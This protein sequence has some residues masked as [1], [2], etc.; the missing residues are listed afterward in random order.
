VDAVAS[1]EGGAFLTLT[2][3]PES[4]EKVVAMESRPERHHSLAAYSIR[5]LGIFAAVVIYA[6]DI[7]YRSANAGFGPDWQCTPQ[8]QGDPVCIK[9]PAR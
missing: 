8:A 2:C 3:Y 5:D 1:V 6:P 7:Q 4:H 9:K